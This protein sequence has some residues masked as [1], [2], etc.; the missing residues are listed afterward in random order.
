MVLVGTSLWE[1]IWWT[2]LVP[3]PPTVI[4]CHPCGGFKSQQ[5]VEAFIRVQGGLAPP[6]Q[7]NILSGGPGFLLLPQQSSEVILVV[8]AEDI[9][10]YLFIES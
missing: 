3:A 10:L 1:G 7:V 4:R 6:D 2:R 5:A 9:R 8:K